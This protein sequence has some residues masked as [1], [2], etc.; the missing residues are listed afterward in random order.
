MPLKQGQSWSRWGL[1]GLAVFAGL[2]V[3][4]NHLDGWF[5][6]L[7]L[8]GVGG[9]FVAWQRLQGA[10]VAS[11]LTF[12]SLTQEH[13]DQKLK[14]VRY[15]VQRLESEAKT[16]N[17]LDRLKPVL[18]TL[19]SDLAA[20]EQE[21][22]RQ[23]LRIAVTGGLGVGKSAIV[24]QLQQWVLEQSFDCEVIEWQC[25]CALG[26]NRS[27][28]VDAAIALKSLQGL[29]SQDLI[30]FVIQGD[31]TQ[32][33][34]EQIQA[35]KA[36]AKTVLV[37]IN[38]SDQYFPIQLEQLQQRINQSLDA[39]ETP[40]ELL[41]I[42]AQPQPILVR[43][44]S[45]KGMI[46]ESEQRPQGQ[47]TP[48]WNHLAQQLTGAGRQQLIWR[49]RLKDLDRVNTF[50]LGHLNGLRRQRA[51][52]LLDRYQWL[53]ASAAFA[54]PLPSLDMIATAAITGKLVMELGAV[55]EHA[56]S[57]KEAQEIATILAAAFV[58]LGVVELSSQL[59]GAALKGHAVTYVAGGLLQAVSAAYLTR[60]AGLSLMEHFEQEHFEQARVEQMSHHGPGTQKTQGFLQSLNPIVERVFQANQRLDVLKQFVQ[61]GMGR[62]QPAR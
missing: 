2:I 49:S 31:L 28:E 62:L 22:A 52:P 30:L 39:M 58:K 25:P 57:L 4:P 43:Q 5:T 3:M 7:S 53:T 34:L 32:S 41:A 24:P 35:L 19:H 27:L 56:F 15:Q 36:Q 54:S 37:L 26:V 29:V 9:A 12:G 23:I 60:I 13:L 20:L 14:T 40:T 48:L 8:L 17:V 45:A 46:Q 50:V 42:A 18:E 51:L 10:R 59:L 6:G 11:V 21:I 38:K 16:L 1:T 55:Y 47:M 61:E 33:E 44:H